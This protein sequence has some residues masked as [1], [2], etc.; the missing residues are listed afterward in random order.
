MPRWENCNKRSYCTILTSDKEKS[1]VH[2]VKNKNRCNLWVGRNLKSWSL[3]FLVSTVTLTKSWKVVESSK[4]YQRMQELHQRKEGKSSYFCPW[5]KKDVVSKS[6]VQ[7]LMN[8]SLWT[9][10]AMENFHLIFS[11]LASQLNLNLWPD[12]SILTCQFWNWITMLRKVKC[13]FMDHILQLSLIRTNLF[14]FNFSL[15]GFSFMS[16]YK[17]QGCRGRGTDI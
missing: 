1:I 3:M 6:C 5:F 12:V 7:K 17:S 13:R 8:K 15:S 10:T 14:L 4:N 2:F 11:I 9:Q 16:I